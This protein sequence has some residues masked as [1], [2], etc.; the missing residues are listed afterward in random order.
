LLW[1]QATREKNGRYFDEEQWAETEAEHELVKK[2]H[3]EHNVLLLG[4]KDLELKKAQDDLATRTAILTKAEKELEKVKQGLQ[5]EV[6]VR[7]AYAASESK[8]DRVAS[9]LKMVARQGVSDITGL[10][11]KLGEP[12]QFIVFRRIISMAD[13]I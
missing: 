2:Q 8:L 4:R 1:S 12:C 3:E 7:Q 11:D 9:G 10:F 13:G 6:I 5:D